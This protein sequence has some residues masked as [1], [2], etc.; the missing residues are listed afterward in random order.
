VKQGLNYRFQKTRRGYPSLNRQ[1]LA[2]TDATYGLP[3][4]L[5][6]PP[7]GYPLALGRPDTGFPFRNHVSKRRCFFC[8]ISFTGL[9]R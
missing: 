5:P 1:R 7:L 9:L 2:W 3:L 8:E 6:A 4:P